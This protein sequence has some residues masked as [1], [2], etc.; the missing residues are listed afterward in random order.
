VAVSFEGIEHLQEPDALLMN[1]VGLLRP[2]GTALISTP[3]ASQYEQGHSG[4]PYHLREYSLDQFK[5]VLSGYFKRIDFYFQWNSGDPL[6][7]SWSLRTLVRSLIPIPIKHF[8]RS[9]L[10]SRG[11]SPAP[12]SFSGSRIPGYASRPFPLA[13]LSLLPG[14]KHAQPSIWIAVCRE[15]VIEKSRLPAKPTGARVVS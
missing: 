6:D 13:Y 10:T 15:P 12:P 7:F 8:V 5:T 11:A 1:M 2:G 9:R 14:L 3:N 4:N